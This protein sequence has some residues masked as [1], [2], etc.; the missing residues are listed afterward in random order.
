MQGWGWVV[1]GAQV[2]EGV[3]RHWQ[4]CGSVVALAGVAGPAG[5]DKLVHRNMARRSMIAI[6]IV[7]LSW[8]RQNSSGCA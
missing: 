8:S 1:R 6:D 2:W 4:V 3:G 7:Q 5:P